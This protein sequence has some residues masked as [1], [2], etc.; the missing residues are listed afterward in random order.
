MEKEGV[1]SPPNHQASARCWRGR[2]IGTRTTRSRGARRTSDR[3]VQGCAQLKADKVR[4]RQPLVLRRGASGA[5][6]HARLAQPLV[7]STCRQQAAERVRANLVPR[8]AC[9]GAWR[10]PRHWLERPSRLR[11]VAHLRRGRR[12]H[13]PHRHPPHRNRAPQTP[14]SSPS[15]PRRAAPPP[16]RRSTPCARPP[17]ARVACKARTSP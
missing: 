13:L 10:R 12:G 15:A 8:D 7:Q 4:G 11:F 14:S 1:V 3:H 9:C 6:K 16:S 2:R 5:S 17:P